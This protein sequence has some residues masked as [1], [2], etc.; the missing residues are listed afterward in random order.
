MLHESNIHNYNAHYGRYSVHCVAVRLTAYTLQASC[1]P[2]LYK[3]GGTKNF[4][5]CSARELKICIP[6]YKI[7]GAAPVHIIHLS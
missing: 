1:T 3:L 7:H 2:K 4:F 5:A 6:H